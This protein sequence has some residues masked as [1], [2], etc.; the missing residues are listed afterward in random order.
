MTNEI[1]EAIR[2][3]EPVDRQESCRKAAGLALSLHKVISGRFRKD[4]ASERADDGANRGTGHYIRLDA[5]LAHSIGEP[6]LKHTTENTTTEEEDNCRAF[7]LWHRYCTYNER[8][9]SSA[10]QSHMLSQFFLLRSIHP[11]P[12]MTR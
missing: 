2:E 3:H 1:R 11:S 4:P 12:L 8:T 10:W 6:H 7:L 5:Q 9:W